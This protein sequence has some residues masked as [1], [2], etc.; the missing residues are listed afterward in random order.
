MVLE[1]TLE[2]PLDY[3]KMEAVNSKANQPGVFIGKT[4]AEAPIPWP[5]DEKSGLIKRPWCWERLK[6]RAEGQKRMRWL[7]NITDSVGTSL[8]K[9]CE[10]VEDRGFWWST[11]HEVTKGRIWL[12]NWTATTVNR[13][14]Q[15]VSWMPLLRYGYKTAMATVW[16]CCLN[17]SLRSLNLGVSICCA[18][19]QS[20]G[21]GLRP[22][23]N[24]RVKWKA[25]TS[26][27]KWAFIWT[28][29][30]DWQLNCNLMR[31]L[32]LEAVS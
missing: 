26:I 28:H 7:D 22:I 10:I 4:D 12:S 3:Q 27:S 19:R 32:E 8:S 15:N 31:N 25:N 13:T 17:P 2:K 20:C 5:L 9:F 30:S 24:H 11:V 21:E 23:N 1:K 18:V 29:S 6:A 16:A 14:W